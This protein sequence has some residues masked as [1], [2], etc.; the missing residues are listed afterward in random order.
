MGPEGIFEPYPQ[1]VRV[2]T[3]VPHAS[4]HQEGTPT[5]PAR[6]FLFLPDWERDY[7]PQLEQYIAEYG[8]RLAR[9]WLT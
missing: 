8:S 7:A 4:Y 3:R 2:G 9:H 1:D 5:M 6:P